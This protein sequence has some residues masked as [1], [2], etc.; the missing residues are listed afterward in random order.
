MKK[1]L[2]T[3][4]FLTVFA[5]PVFASGQAHHHHHHHHHPHSL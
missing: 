4:L 1:L 3:A 5:S 2:A